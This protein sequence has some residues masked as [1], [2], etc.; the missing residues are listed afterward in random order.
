MTDDT[1][2]K[3]RAGKLAQIRAL[4]ARTVK[5]GCTEAEAKTAAAAVDRLMATY[6]IGLDEITVKEQAIVQIVVAGAA[7]HPVF[8]AGAAIARFTD[9]RYWIQGGSG[10]LY[11][12]FQVD[13]EIAEY[14]TH[15]FKRSIDRDSMHFTMFNLE[16]AQDDKGGQRQRLTSFQI[17]MAGRLGERL[18]ELKSKRDFTQ[19]TSGRDLV[20]I[21]TPLIEQAFKDL[22]IQLGYSARAYGGRSSHQGSF[23]AGRSAGDKVALNAG[24]AARASVG[25]RIK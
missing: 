8:H 12:G 20:A 24:I 1:E 19:K 17:G 5:N 25:G 3:V 21:K 11:F 16:Y 7:N 6:E 13:T 10:L 2:K 18:G 9:C 23:D 22:G 4:M 15:L 14:L